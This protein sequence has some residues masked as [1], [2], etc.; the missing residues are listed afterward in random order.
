MPLWQAVL[1]GSGKEKKPCNRSHEV[2]TLEKTRI[3]RQG[4]KK[5]GATSSRGLFFKET[6][7]RESRAVI[8]LCDQKRGN[9]KRER[10][11][12]PVRFWTD[13]E[14]Y[15][16]GGRERTTRT[17]EDQGPLRCRVKRSAGRE[18]GIG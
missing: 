5:K 14:V 16:V 8:A 15:G 3:P 18:K 10:T 13:W 6:R 4:G 12:R 7:N 11:I 1:V 9:N 17:N 2:F